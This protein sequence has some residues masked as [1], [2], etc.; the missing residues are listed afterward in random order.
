MNKIAVLAVGAVI[1]E[2]SKNVA[3]SHCRVSTDEVAWVPIDLSMHTAEGPQPCLQFDRHPTSQNGT[4]QHPTVL[5]HRAS[6][7][8]MLSDRLS[9][10]ETSDG[11]RFSH[12]LEMNWP[13]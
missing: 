1:D 8:G 5:R 2:R 4:D 7:D 13:A 12:P 10:T 6:A 9:K 11:F 3:F